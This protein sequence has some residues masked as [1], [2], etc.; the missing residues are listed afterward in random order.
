VLGK[1]KAGVDDDLKEF[2][3]HIVFKANELFNQNGMEF[4]PQVQ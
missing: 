1:Q 4:P 3:I 2:Y